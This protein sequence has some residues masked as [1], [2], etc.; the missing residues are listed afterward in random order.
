MS[1]PGVFSH[2]LPRVPLGRRA[3]VL[4]V[5]ASPHTGLTPGDPYDAVDPRQFAEAYLSRDK[6]GSQ[7]PASAGLRCSSASPPRLCR[8]SSLFQRVFFERDSILALGLLETHLN[9][10][11]RRYEAVDHREDV[12]GNRIE[13]I[14]PVHQRQY[15]LVLLGSVGGQLLVSFTYTHSCTFVYPVLPSAKAIS[16]KM[17]RT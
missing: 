10:P 7:H 8:S 5:S 6:K 17:V 12:H 13:D 15:P 1:P 16:R 9:V 3:P 11:S 2:H 4:I 14:S